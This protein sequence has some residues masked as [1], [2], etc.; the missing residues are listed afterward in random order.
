MSDEQDTRPAG[1]V[2]WGDGYVDALGA[3]GLQAGATKGFVT[4]EQGPPKVGEARGERRMWVD[5]WGT[6]RGMREFGETYYSAHRACRERERCIG[7]V[8]QWGL[9]EAKYGSREGRKGRR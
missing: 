2:T 6:A 8:W 1:R 5:G 9:R 7:T 4:L 3:G